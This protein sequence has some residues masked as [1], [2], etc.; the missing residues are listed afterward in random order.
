MVGD[1]HQT[2]LHSFLPFLSSYTSLSVTLTVCRCSFAGLALAFYPVSH[3]AWLIYCCRRWA[4]AH[5]CLYLVVLWPLWRQRQHQPLANYFETKGNDNLHTVRESH[6][7]R[8]T[9]NHIIIIK[10]KPLN[11]NHTKKNKFIVF[12]INK[13]STQ[14]ST[15]YSAQLVLA[16]GVVD[17][18]AILLFFNL[19]RLLLPAFI[20]L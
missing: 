12:R 10:H 9:N 3:W 20:I 19:F 7:H 11:S 14:R 8:Q 6:R 15:E 13:F 4:A 1:A 2:M 18:T 16:A 17:Q 5:M